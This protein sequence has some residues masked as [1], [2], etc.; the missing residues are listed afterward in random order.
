MGEWGER[1]GDQA[2]AANVSTFERSIRTAAS[3]LWGVRWVRARITRPANVKLGREP[4]AH[5][6]AAIGER[7]GQYLCR[8]D[9][10]TRST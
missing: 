8:A 2:R 1:C 5:E 4:F 6:A 9:Q 10:P 3:N 7:F